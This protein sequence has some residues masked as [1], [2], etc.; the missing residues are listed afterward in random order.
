MEY[1]ERLKKLGI[2][3]L[4]ARRKGL[5]LCLAY[6]IIHGLTD[7]DP[8]LF[9]LRDGKDTRLCHG[10]KLDHCVVRKQWEQGL[11]HVRVPPLWNKLPEAAFK[12]LE[13]FKQELKVRGI[14]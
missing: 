12:S 7:P 14:L 8:R 2:P 9:R 10:L 1:D 3:S 13:E 6:K 5:D 4:E 11:F